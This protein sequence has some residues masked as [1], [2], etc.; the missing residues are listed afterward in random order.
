MS[1]APAKRAWVPREAWRQEKAVVWVRKAVACPH[2]FFAFDRSKAQSDRSH[3]YQSRRGVRRD[4]L[5][6]LL[7]PEGGVDCWVEFK[8]GSAKVNFDDPDDGQAKMIADLRM[9]GRNADWCRTIEEMCALYRIWGVPLVTNAEYLALHYDGMVDSRIAK[10]EGT[11]LASKAK[12]ATRTKPQVRF[13]A[14][15]GFARRAAAKGIQV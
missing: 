2:K 15:K 10:A 9:L 5:D 3:L 12:R 1:D 4:T 14:G 11:T 13:S 6:T 7:V 8:A